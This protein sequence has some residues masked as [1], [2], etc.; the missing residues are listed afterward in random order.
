MNQ[1]TLVGRLGKDPE[2]RTTGSGMVVASLSVATTERKKEGDKWVEFAEWH[3][4]TVFGRMAENVA[5]YKKKGEQIAVT[6]RLKTDKWQDK[7]GNDRYTTA[8]IADNIEFIGGSG[9]GG[10][11]SSPEPEPESKKGYDKN[12][13]DDEIPFR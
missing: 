3:K 5:R 10:R 12:T 2:T 8:I 7:D 1:V 11:A 6:G 4:V 9:D 13:P